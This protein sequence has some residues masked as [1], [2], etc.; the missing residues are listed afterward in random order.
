MR[1]K[2]TRTQHLADADADAVADSTRNQTPRRVI[3]T[4]VG[5]RLATAIHTP[6]DDMAKIVAFGHKLEQT[7]GQKQ[8]QFSGLSE[9]LKFS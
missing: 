8:Q 7:L 6:G 3:A 4:A 2:V 9:K 5:C 1:H